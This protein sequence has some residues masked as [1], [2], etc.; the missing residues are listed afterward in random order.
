[1]DRDDAA[2]APEPEVSCDVAVVGAGVGG[3]YSAWRLIEAGA[4][5]GS[6]VCLFE[7]SDRIGGR[8]YSLHHVGKAQHESFRGSRK[9]VSKRPK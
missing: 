1:M 2:A 3:A 6:G 8:A 4:V 7:R 9:A 5:P